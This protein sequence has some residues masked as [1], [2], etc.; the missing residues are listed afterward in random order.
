MGIGERFSEEEI[1]EF[2]RY[3]P[4]DTTTGVFDYV[5]FIRLL[6]HGSKDS[7]EALE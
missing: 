2:L 5:E 4:V 1:S 6:K 7:N 3:A